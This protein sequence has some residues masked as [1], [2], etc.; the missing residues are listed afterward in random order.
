MA[1]KP[2][3][4]VPVAPLLGNLPLHLSSNGAN[5]RDVMYNPAKAADAA[6]E[7]YTWFRPDAGSGLMMHSGLA[8]EIAETNMYDWPGQPGKNVP[9]YTTYQCHEIEYMSADEYPELLGDIT[10]FILKKMIPRSFPGLAGL[11]QIALNPSFHLGTT[12]LQT[13]MAPPVLEA[14]DKLAQM[15]AHEAA[16]NAESARVDAALLEFGIPPLFN[17]MGLAP[18]DAISDNLRGTTGAWEDLLDRPDLVAAACDVIADLQI[19]GWQYFR[20]VDMPVKRVFF[21]LHKGMDGLMS[22]AQFD[23]IYWQPLLKC[24]NAL[25][26]M[27]VISMIYGEGYYNTRID[28]MEGLPVGQTI[29]HMEYADPA[30]CKKAFDGIACL[31]GFVPI[32]NLHMGSKEKVIDETKRVLDVLADGSGY[33]FDTGAGIEFAQRENFE[34]MIETVREWG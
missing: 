7:F 29:V 8:N 27:G 3:P 12:L 13:L 6:I 26:D 5:F 10:G 32:V 24:V 22:P 14:Y 17:G 30:A 9:D 34:A 25:A 28:H 19:A 15:A 20:Y 4:R 31:S 23:S 21:P 33:I 18:F 16:M 1:L 2:T 11:G